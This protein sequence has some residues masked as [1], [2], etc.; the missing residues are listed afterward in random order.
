MDLASEWNANLSDDKKKKI[1]QLVHGVDN[2]ENP[3]L[4]I[5]GW[6]QFGLTSYLL[7]SSDY[8][9]LGIDKVGSYEQ[10]FSFYSL[11]SKLGDPVSRRVDLKSD[12][13]HSLQSRRF[14]GGLVVVNGDSNIA[15]KY[16]LSKEMLDETNSV[17]SGEIT[18]LPHT[19]RIFYDFP[20]TT[21]NYNQN[22]QSK[23]GFFNK[24]VKVN[25]STSET[26][27]DNLVTY[28][29]IDDDVQKIY[30]GEIV[31]P[32]GSH[33]LYYWSEDT[34]PDSSSVEE[35]KSIDFKID[36]TAPPVAVPKSPLYTFKNILTLKLDKNID[37]TQMFVNDSEIIYNSSGQYWHM[38]Q[39]L[40]VG[41]TK[42]LIIKTM[43]LAGNNSNSALVVTRRR[44]GDAVSNLQAGIDKVNIYDFSA[45]LSFWGTNNYSTDFNGDG[46]TDI[47]DFS[48]MLLNWTN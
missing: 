39:Q 28:Y 46:T 6:A 10:I 9:W 7:G 32:E 2:A 22:Y 41:E 21:A 24:E 36:L 5:N 48:D 13:D 16:I 11:T 1:F 34:G 19:G 17:I 47:Y 44:I 26:V 27:H 45:L 3:A 15:Q 37:I 14:S 29:R 12:T 40:N 23:N 35:E 8:S 30:S 4:G 31:I 33:T 42:T 18:L 38:D 25:L 20:I 43:D